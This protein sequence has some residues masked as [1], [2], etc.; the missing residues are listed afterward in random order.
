MRLRSARCYAGGDV[1]GR[2]SLPGSET[3]SPFTAVLGPQ[4]SAK[5]RGTPKILIR[6]LDFRFAEA[7]HFDG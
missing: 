7:E 3:R 6:R 1:R 2:T 4:D 5:V